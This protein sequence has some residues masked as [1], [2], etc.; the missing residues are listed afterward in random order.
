MIF[1]LRPLIERCVVRNE[2]ATIR[3]WDPEG[4]NTYA[5]DLSGLTL[6][7]ESFLDFLGSE[8]DSSGVP[9]STLCFELTETSVIANFDEAILF[10][11]TMREL[12][13]RFALDDFGVGMS[14]LTYLKR[15]TVDFV[16]IDGSFVRGMLDNESDRLT[17]EMINKI[18]HLPGK[19]TIAEF[20]ETPEHLEALLVVGV[21]YVQGFAIASPMAF[22]ACDAFP[23][24]SAGG[25]ALPEGKAAEKS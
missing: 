8:L 1:G 15:L 9:V 7:D 13:C 18:A 10:M 20:A 23:R 2:P 16:K 5:I 22:E 3:Q 24:R 19:R 17:V 14:S 21:D 4:C 6:T 12:G 25:S 11:D